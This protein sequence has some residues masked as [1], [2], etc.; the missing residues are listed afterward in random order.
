MALNRYAKPRQL[1]KNAQRK[2]AKAALK[3]SPEKQAADAGD[4]HDGSATLTSSV[5]NANARLASAEAPAADSASAMSAKANTMLMPPADKPA[6]I[7]PIA[8]TEVVAA[9]QLND[10]D[11]VLRETRSAAPTMALASAEA[12]A[13]PV[14]PVVATRKEDSAWDQTS[15]IGK[16]FIAFGALLTMA[17]AARMFMA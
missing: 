1:K 7:Q 10:V 17:S 2:P 8:E 15:L 6:D 13:A 5:A 4:V 3:S 16:I 12:P 9:D 14:A 11:R